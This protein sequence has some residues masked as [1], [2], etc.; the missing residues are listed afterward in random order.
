M[1][2]LLLIEEQKNDVAGDCDADAD[3]RHADGDGDACAAVFMLVH[4]SS[5]SPLVPASA[6]VVCSA[7][8]SFINQGNNQPGLV[9]VSVDSR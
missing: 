7:G 9:S 2:A 8:A 4:P 1:W 5:L 3:G 6:P